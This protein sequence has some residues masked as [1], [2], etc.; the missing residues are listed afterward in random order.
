MIELKIQLDDID[1]SG[2]AELAMPVVKEK[3]GE[4]GGFFGGLIGNHVPESA[5]NGA[6]NGFLKFLSPEQRD[7]IALS[8]I[9]KYEDKIVKLLQNTASDKGVKI[10]VKSL[11][12]NKAD[13]KE[14]L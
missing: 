8:L 12:A 2:I 3:L 6:F 11:S 4:N 10:T 5:L 7:D 9:N 1:Y 13:K 14:T